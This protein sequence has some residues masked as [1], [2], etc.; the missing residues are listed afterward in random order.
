ML[1]PLNPLL[2]TNFA[3]QGAKSTASVPLGASNSTTGCVFV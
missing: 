3:P 1:D 2:D